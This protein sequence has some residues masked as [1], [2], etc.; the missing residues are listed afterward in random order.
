MIKLVSLVTKDFLEKG[1]IYEGKRQ[2]RLIDEYW[3]YVDDNTVDIHK[4]GYYI[5]VPPEIDNKSALQSVWCPLNNF[6]PLV[7]FRDQRIDEII[8]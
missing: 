1:K 2:S 4:D 7:D 8:N 3:N 6:I 5:T